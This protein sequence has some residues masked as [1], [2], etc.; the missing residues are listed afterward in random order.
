MPDRLA[1]V[2][3]V[4]GRHEHLAVQRHHLARG[5]AVPTLHVVVA[6]DDPDVT[7]VVAAEPSLPTRVVPLASHPAG[8]PVGAA[9]NAGV[10]AALAAGAGSLVLLDVD[11]LPGP[12][13]LSRYA[14]A[15]TAHPGAVLCGPVTYLPPAAGRDWRRDDPTVLRHPHEARPDPAVGETVELPAAL[16][17][18]LSFAL[19]AQTWLRLGGFYEGYVGYGAEDTDFGAHAVESGVPLLVAGGADA[20]HQ[21]HPVSRPPVEHLDDI[22]RNSAVYLRRRGTLPMQGWV[23][24]FAADGLVEPGPT[25]A[26]RRTNAPRVLTI[27]GRHP[28]LDAV[29]PDSVVRVDPD[30]V[31]GWDPDP[32]LDP[33]LLPAEGIDV[34]H[35]HFGYDHVAPA[36]LQRWVDR[37]AE[38][39]IPLVVTVHDLRNPHHP[40]RT[41]HDEHLTVLL[42]AARRIYTLTVAAADECADRFGRRPEVIAHPTLLDAADVEQALVAASEAD[43]GPF[44]LVPLKNLRTNVVDPGDV[45]RA[46]VEGAATAGARVRVL[47]QPEA[48]GRPEV[49]DVLAAADRGELDL[50]VT[51]YQPAAE[52]NALVASAHAIVLPYR[53]GTHS[54]WAELARDLGTHVVAPDGGHV[55]S[56]WADVVGYGN[57]ESD[58]LDPVGLA[59]AV[60]TVCRR[61]P[62]E[63]ADRRGREAQRDLVRAEHDALY[64]CLARR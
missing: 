22:V 21:H 61:P 25:G 5:A 6:I 28:Y 35:L 44:V 54:G 26:P 58:G 51:G 41:R 17:W 34:V 11:C 3:V 53:F 30:R 36:E 32:L 1:V 47:L 62:A 42:A 33:A 52:L 2:T 57:N 20:Y 55:R 8:L 37:L 40:D 38:L 39:R 63:P 60:A 23:D 50:V 64:R 14:A 13:L 16:F 46:V 48:V 31:A 43:R 56:Q 4:S 59:R 18:S 24:G 9:R 12:Q 27:P 15:L 49:A 29:L 19:T 7:D 45:V 10:A